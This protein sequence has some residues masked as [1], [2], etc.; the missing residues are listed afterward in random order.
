MM[1]GNRI[2]FSI[3]IVNYNSGS[4]LRECIGSILKFLQ[5]FEIIIYDNAS[6]DKSI[7]E[8]QHCFPDDKRIKILRGEK[9]IG[10][11]AANNR[12]A[13][14]ATG[15]FLHFLNPDIVVNEN[16]AADYK[17]IAESGQKAVY[18]TRLCDESGNITRNKHIIPT[19]GNYLNRIF[20]PHKTGYWNIGASLIS[21]RS[22]FVKTGGW[23]E[24]Y[25]MY[26]EDLDLFY[27]LHK[28]SIPVIYL[29]T[30]IIH[31]G[32]GTTGKIWSETERSMRVERSFRNF[33]RKYD[34]NIDYFLV[35]PIQLIY[36]LFHTPQTFFFQT[37]IFFRTI[38]TK[39]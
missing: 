1:N 15:N 27:K 6:S 28:L 8:V 30:D 16:L 38:F 3:I 31:V 25:F 13:E 12:A 24:D 14:V 20:F 33:Y 17:L 21:S 34:L 11:A 5:D 29:E 36:I 10:F 19:I 26:A 9:N 35:R 37:G 23:P 22:N 18:V 32:K 7:E 2:L 39:E 4:F